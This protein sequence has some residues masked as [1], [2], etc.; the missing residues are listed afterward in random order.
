MLG[1]TEGLARQMLQVRADI[2]SLQEGRD[3][4]QEEFSTLKVKFMEEREKLSA[5][6]ARFMEEREEL[7]AL[8]ARLI[9]GREEELH[10]RDVVE[11]HESL[12]RCLQGMESPPSRLGN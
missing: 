11:L 7:S 10:E 4:D 1:A 2:R 5:L 6:K 9:E 8:K 12:D 3:Q